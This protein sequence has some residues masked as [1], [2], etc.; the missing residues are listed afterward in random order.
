MVTRNDTLAEQI[1]H[2]DEEMLALQ[3]EFPSNVFD[4]TDNKETALIPQVQSM[5]EYILLHYKRAIIDELCRRISNEYA[6]EMM[7]APVS[8]IED[9]GRILHMEFWRESFIS[10]IAEVRLSIDLMT[11]DEIVSQEY[12]MEI[13]FDME[14]GIAY[15]Y[16]TIRPYNRSLTTEPLPNNR[17]LLSEYLIPILRK[18][19]IEEGAEALL[20]QYYHEALTGSGKHSAFVLAERMG[21]QVMYLALHGRIRTLSILFFCTGEVEV[22]DDARKDEPAYMVHIPA[23]TIVINTN[24]VHKDHSQLEV[25]HECIHYDWHYMFYRLQDIHNND[26]KQ[27]N[28]RRIACK[29]TK[30]PENPLK[31]MEWQARRGSFGLMMPL[32]HMRPTVSKEMERWTGMNFHAGEKMERVARGISHEHEL[33]KFRVRARL[34]QMGYVGAKGA[35]NYVDGRYILPFAFSTENGAGNYTF[36]IDRRSA[37]IEYERSPEFRE[38]IS[39]GQ[40]I[41]VDGHLCLND[42]QYVTETSQG[43]RLTKWANAHVDACCLRFVSV[44]EATPDGEYHY[45]ALNSDEEY[46]CH[47]LTFADDTQSLS[48]QEQIAAMSRILDTL[49]VSFHEALEYMMRM[50]KVTIEQL[51]EK[52]SLSSRT[53]SRLRTEERREYSI[54]QVIAICVALKLP[55][56]MS[57]ELLERAG[58]CL[59]RNALHRAYRF[60][61]DCMF[62]DSVE[63]VQKFLSASGFPA[64]KLKNDAVSA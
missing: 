24:A 7:D 15:R 1:T 55:P 35:L 27:L 63:D 41:Y 57:N 11:R 54:E 49:P 23:N 29:K 39:S 5:R 6:T 12:I 4:I 56:W 30:R 38:R 9:T 32:S 52:S 26:V 47:Y 8:A 20:A 50:Q 33:P 22:K 2:A 18:D 28:L 48:R 59:R 25:Y 46:N 36:V 53:I 40:Y 17:W 61:L 64:L 37:Y 19:E 31:W 16:G 14:E 45:G 42:P 10:L 44:Y 51:E 43:L 13:Y 34:I 3:P 58:L 21:L 62:M 60:V